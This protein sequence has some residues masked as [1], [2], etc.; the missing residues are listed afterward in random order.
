MDEI[1]ECY[2]LR[3]EDLAC[4]V[5]Y[6]ANMLYYLYVGL[7]LA[8]FSFLFALQSIC[9]AWRCHETGYWLRYRVGD[10]STVSARLHVIMSIYF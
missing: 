9:L 8:T 7:L 1:L 6:P 10:T 2:F 5:T 3:P 4:H